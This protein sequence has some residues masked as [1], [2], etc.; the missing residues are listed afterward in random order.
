[1]TTSS[2]NTDRISNIHLTL[3][4]YPI[5]KVNIRA[6][7]RQELFER[8]II[9]EDAFEAEAHKK[10]LL[11]QELEGLKDPFAQED[12]DVWELR[13]RH[14]RDGMTDFYFA[15][16]LPYELFEDIIRNVI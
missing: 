10:A 1:M 9:Q 2:A 7:M 12:A 11:S 13:L 3:L 5:L 6:R 15:Y 4:Q 16:N 14:I 8:G